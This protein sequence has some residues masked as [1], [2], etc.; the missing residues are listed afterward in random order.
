MES[1]LNRYRNIT[2]LVIV[3]G[4]QLLLLAY[5]VKSRQE[6]PAIRGW[7]VAAYVPVAKILEGVRSNTLGLLD[8]Y[9]DLL[10]AQD[11]NRNLNREVERLRLENQFLKTELATADRAKALS[12]FQQRSPSRL[13][14]A[15]VVGMVT[16]GAREVF[17]DRGSK[18]G[19]Q[20]GMAVITPDGIAGKITAAYSSGA[21]VLL[22]TDPSFG[23]GVI[24]TKSRIHGTVKGQGHGSVLVEYIPNEQPV[25]VGEW[26][27][28]SGD[29]RVFPKGLPVGRVHLV[30]PGKMF[31]QEVFL[32]PSGLHNGLEEVLVVIEGVHQPV[33]EQQEVEQPFHTLEPPPMDEPAAPE[34]QPV[35]PAG[36]DTDADEIL[37][38]YKAARSGAPAPKAVP[39]DPIPEPAPA[40]P[41]APTPAPAQPPRR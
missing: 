17:I 22:L 37:A 20:K 31:F 8:R 12:L 23:A 21:Q 18:D 6:V 16:G 34:A 24:S 26:F 10:H 35:T 7:A 28:T 14:A 36:I 39:P 40:S 38:R 3:L 19:I 15:R 30:R 25:A 29:D 11:R 27:F 32:T 13:L 41:T 5:Q 1:I 2:V 4:A 9:S 33:P